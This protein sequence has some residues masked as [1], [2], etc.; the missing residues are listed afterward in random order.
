M[1]RDISH[2]VLGGG[3]PSSPFRARCAYPSIMGH[4]ADAASLA[5]LCG[6]TLGLNVRTT[7]RA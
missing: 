6:V 5:I 4:F 7:N 2:N 3:T 1:I